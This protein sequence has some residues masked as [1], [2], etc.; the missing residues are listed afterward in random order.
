MKH[1]INFGLVC[2]CVWLISFLI[3]FEHPIE[4][5]DITDAKFQHMCELNSDFVLTYC[6]PF[7][8]EYYENCLLGIELF[9]YDCNEDYNP[10]MPYLQDKW[11]QWFWIIVLITNAL[12]LLYNYTYWIDKDTKEEYGKEDIEANLKEEL[13]Y[14]RT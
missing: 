3:Y 12:T 1:I 14:M 2:L 13:L 4:N 6:F 5:D 9:E 7:A 8:L 10:R 11:V